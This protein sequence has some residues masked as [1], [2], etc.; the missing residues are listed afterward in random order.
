MKARD[1]PGFFTMNDSWA[2]YRIGD[3]MRY[4]QITEKR[5]KRTGLGNII[6]QAM[7]AKNS[8]SSEAKNAIQEWTSCN[9]DTGKLE[10]A[11]RANSPLAIEIQHAFQPV[12]KM[13]RST[14]G[15]TITLYRGQ[16][17]YTKEQ[18]T[19]DRVLFS[20]TSE[21]TVAHQFI[22]T[23]KPYQ[24][25]DDVQIQQAI[26]QFKLKGFCKLGNKTY[27]ISSEDPDDYVIYRGTSYMTTGC[28]ED[29]EDDIRYDNQDNIDMNAD[30]VNT[31]K[32]VKANIPISAIVWVDNDLNCKEFITTVNPGI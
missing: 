24:V 32:V 3:I 7:K 11:F 26:D 5:E 22:N 2:K 31:G 10:L 27:K 8:L 13:M 14:Y 17:H 19:P 25:F 23:H 30:M 16:R 18:L 15:D 4:W 21:P 6:A 29:F 12:R 20:W 28:R 1:F 9:W